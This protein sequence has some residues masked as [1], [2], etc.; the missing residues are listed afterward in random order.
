LLA[1]HAGV[2]GSVQGSEAEAKRLLSRSRGIAYAAVDGYQTLAIVRQT[3]GA[4]SAALEARRNATT[5][6]RSAGLKEREA[7]LMTN[8][9]FAL[10]TIGARQEARTAIETGLALA[11]AI[12]SQ[13][14]VRHAQ[15]ILLGWAC[16]FGSDKQLD[17]Q[18]QSAGRRRHAWPSGVWAAPDRPNL[19]MLFYAAA[20][21]CA[22]R[23][24][25]PNRRA[26]TCSC[27]WRRKAY[28]RRPRDVLAVALAMWAEA[29]R[30]CNNLAPAVENH[31]QLRSSS[32]RG[33]SELLNESVVFL[34]LYDALTDSGASRRAHDLLK[35]ALPPLLRRLHGLAGTPYARTFLSDLHANARV[36]ALA[37][38]E[39]LLPEAIQRVLERT[40]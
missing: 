31:G 30:A 5:A 7:M 25:S 1:P 32:N 40:A 35:K 10:T 24:S 6:A 8:L 37:E 23:R 39:G 15:M 22:R 17:L 29:E 18:V 21:S 3:Q 19:G 13:G 4:L 16:S 11:D 36:V 2:R 14:A 9:G 38:D 12:G 26:L 20:S 28:R 34:S 27:A 33:A